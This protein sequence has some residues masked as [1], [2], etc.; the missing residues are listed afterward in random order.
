MDDSGENGR[1]S[2]GGRELLDGDG[3][4]KAAP[5]ILTEVAVVKG[6]DVSLHPGPVPVDRRDD[7]VDDE[8]RDPPRKRPPVSTLVSSTTNSPDSADGDDPEE[9][10]KAEERRVVDWPAR[11]GI[12][13]VISKE[14]RARERRQTGWG[15]QEGVEGHPSVREPRNDGLDLGAGEESMGDVLESSG[16]AAG[17]GGAAGEGGVDRASSLTYVG[18]EGVAAN[19]PVEDTPRSDDEGGRQSGVEEG[20]PYLREGAAEVRSGRVTTNSLPLSPGGTWGDGVQGQPGGRGVEGKRTVGMGVVRSAANLSGG[21]LTSSSHSTPPFLHASKTQEE[22]LGIRG[23]GG[24]RGG[25]RNIQG[26][27]SRPDGPHIRITGDRGGRARGT[28]EGVLP[29]EAL[30]GVANGHINE[31]DGRRRDAARQAP[32][33]WIQLHVVV[34][35]DEPRFR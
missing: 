24:S 16:G 21:S 5:P 18:E 3:G 32:D 29:S 35:P 14:D 4:I 2:P 12:G 25:S 15:D 20:Q 8:Q 27:E 31:G 30:P 7:R 19:L 6:A 9:V 10:P 26:P 28:P 17:G 33:R 1:G 23:G 22:E 13:R 34:H 11:P